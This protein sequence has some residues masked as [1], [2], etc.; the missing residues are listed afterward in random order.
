MEQQAKLEAYKKKENVVPPVV[1]QTWHTKDMHYVWVEQFKTMKQ[2]NSHIEFKLFTDEECR[3]YIKLNFDNKVLWAY[4]SLAPTAFK[5]DLWRYCVLY[6]EGGVYLDIKLLCY[7]IDLLRKEEFLRVEDI[8]QAPCEAGTLETYYDEKYYSD[9]SIKPGIWQAVMASVAGN[10]ILKQVIDSVVDNVFNNYYGF[11]PLYITGPIALC[12]IVDSNKIPTGD[13]KLHKVHEQTEWIH[14]VFYGVPIVKL[15]DY[16]RHYSNHNYN[17]KVDHTKQHYSAMWKNG[18]VYKPHCIDPIR[19]VPT[20]S[21]IKPNDVMNVCKLSKGLYLVEKP[22]NR[23]SMI[24]DITLVSTG[25]LVLNITLFNN[26]TKRYERVPFP[27]YDKKQV[28]SGFRDPKV[29]HDSVTFNTK[30]NGAHFTVYV[31]SSMNIKNTNTWIPVK[32]NLL[33]FFNIR[34]QEYCVTSWTPHVEIAKFTKS[35]SKPLD[36]HKTLFKYSGCAHTDWATNGIK[37][38]EEIWFLGRRTI[39]RKPKILYEED[40]YKNIGKYVIVSYCYYWI[41]L[42]NSLTTI[43]RSCIFQPSSEKFHKVS[44]ISYDVKTDTISIDATSY[45]NWSKTLVFSKNSFDDLIWI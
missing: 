14:V 22:K 6:K 28:I 13:M 36:E 10:K 3:E 32:S 21:L 23:L 9:A 11:N 8:P 43:K 5:A 33:S 16:Y 12:S 30:V 35:S 20:E 2:L 18:L 34:D 19:T 41:I 38:G 15:I 26:R 4:D 37:I 39:R 44:D 24:D 1:Y 27:P 45:N 17:V 42:G 25:N 7:D 29:Y 40:G 31:P